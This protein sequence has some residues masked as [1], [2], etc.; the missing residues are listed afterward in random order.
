MQAKTLYWNPERAAC[1][2]GNRNERLYELDSTMKDKMAQKMD[3]FQ[4][5]DIVS[6]DTNSLRE[7]S[8]EQ[9]KIKKRIGSHAMSR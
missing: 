4:R 5:K 7:L 9:D 6:I 3:G 2:N 8:I 1:L